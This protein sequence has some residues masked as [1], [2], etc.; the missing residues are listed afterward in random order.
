MSTKRK[1]RQGTLDAFKR[2]KAF[3]TPEQEPIKNKIVKKQKSSPS[4][5]VKKKLV[6]AHQENLP[7]SIYK[8]CKYDMRGVSKTIAKEYVDAS[9]QIEQICT[10]PFDFGRSIQY[11]ALSGICYEERLVDSFLSGKI[12]LNKNKQKMFLKVVSNQTMK[13][14]MEELSNEYDCNETCIQRALYL[15]N[16]DVDKVKVLLD[17]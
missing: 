5:S 14:K 16:G 6:L 3:V 4:S 2:T 13:N 1:R 9:S 15:M 7:L 17:E 11:G 8:N 10:I 12:L